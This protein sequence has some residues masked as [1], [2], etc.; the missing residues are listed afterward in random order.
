[1]S[2][3]ARSGAS[4]ILSSSRVSGNDNL[5]IVC[6]ECLG[7][8]VRNAWSKAV[9]EVFPN[10]PLSWKRPWEE[11]SPEWQE[12]NIRVGKAVAEFLERQSDEL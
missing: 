9:T 11:V 4:C 7:R 3:S 10:A 5:G 6:P 1:M 8:I 12:V 2:I